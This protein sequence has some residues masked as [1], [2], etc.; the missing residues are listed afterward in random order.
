MSK[1][2]IL[3]AVFRS[4]GAYP[5]GWRYPGA[6]ANP[7]AD[8]VVLR[9]TAKLAEAAGLDYLF[10]GDWLSTGSD[11][12]FSDPCLLA[13]IDPLS[14]V[15]YLAGV[16]R[17]IGLI[18]TVNTTYSDPYSI[19][20][21]TA[22][23]DRLSNGRA[24]VNLVTGADPRAD[25]NHGHDPHNEHSIRYDRATE[26]VLAMQLLWDSWE[27]DAF[28]QDKATGK[29][30]DPGKVHRADFVGEHVR[31]AGVLNVPRPVQGHLPLVHAGTAVRSRHLVCD[32]ANLSIVALRSRDE[33]VA[34]T[35]G[36]K[37]QAAAIGR[38]PDEIKVIT[39]ILPIVA[40]TTEEAWEIFDTL[41]ALVPLDDDSQV[42]GS[43]DFPKGRTIRAL[44][45][46]V[47]VALGPRHLDD[48]VSARDAA[49]FGELGHS[50]IETV[51]ARTGRKIGSLTRPVTFRH[52]LVTHLIPSAVVVGD[53]RAVAD[54][55][56][57]WFRAGAVDG[58][59]VLTAFMGDQ[60]EAFTQLVV[61][62]LV[63]RGLFR[64]KYEGRT[65]RDHLGL[66]RP[67]NLHV[68]RARAVEA[69]RAK[70]TA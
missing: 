59:N 8:P 33:A 25:A 56:E 44:S 17:R 20:R 2:I 26:F 1:Q 27:D 7:L 51:T 28:T 58:F 31:V 18:A 38:D 6:H 53:A 54:H 66:K 29:L 30:I 35:A 42:A 50:L 63:R 62:E 36:L 60:F 34:F 48:E 57:A 23:V 67:E 14:A 13:R 19:A 15:T 11:L 55:F 49:R 4:L 37:A 64:T 12:Q 39:P 68:A 9:K 70:R 52:L 22:S 69:E 47:G 46:V 41:I 61:P 24:G 21:A 16:T 3:G 40:E 5:S 10:F 43:P 45:G 32:L 65:L